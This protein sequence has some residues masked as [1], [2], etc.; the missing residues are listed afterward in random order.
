MPSSSIFKSQA[1]LIFLL[2]ISVSAQSTLT[3]P[4]TVTVQDQTGLPIA[5]ATVTLPAGSSNGT[6]LRTDADGKAVFPDVSVGARTL[7]VTATGFS[8]LTHTASLD[9]LR[10]GTIRIVLAP[11]VISEEVVISATRTETRVSDTP[12]SIAV[13]TGEDLDSS[14]AARLD[15]ALRQIPGFSLFRRS[16]SRVANPTTQGVSLR[17]VGAS[18]AS[19]AVVLEDG[20]PL[21]DPFG[22]W[23]YWGRVPRASVSSIEVVRGG[24]SSLYGSDALGGVVN[25][26]TRK[27]SQRAL[28]ME[29]SYGTQETFDGSLFTA[30]KKGKWSASLAAEVF[31][32][33]GYIL[34]EKPARGR[35]DV[36]ANS[37][38]GAV[39][40]TVQREFA[41]DST[42]FVRGSFFNETRSNGTPLQTNSTHIRQLSGGADFSFPT[43]GNFGL[44]LYSGIERFDQ[45]FTAASA[46]RGSE[47]L[48][49]VQRVPSQATGAGF[50]WMRP[51]G[52][53]TIVAG[54]DAREVRGAS[55]EIVFIA[56]TASSLV[57]AGGR[58]RS[59][60][61]F[62][63]DLVRLSPR[64]L[65]KLNLRVDGWNNFR[66]QS[67]TR[68]LR[69]PGLISA[70][71]FQ[72]RS[73]H[74]VSPHL[75]ALYS[76]NDNLSFSASFYKAFRAP[77]LNE[78]YR[79]FRVGDV[80]TLANENLRSER[81]SGI[82]L[83]TAL[84]LLNGK[85]R[86]RSTFFLAEVSQPVTNVTIGIAPGLITRKRQNLGKNRSTGLEAEVEGR[87]G[88]HWNLTA[89]YLF[90]N[91]IVSDFPPNPS[92]T[93]LR[94][95]QVPR[96]QATF[97]LRYSGTGGLIAALQGRGSSS[98][99]DDDQNLFRLN[100]YF[101]VDGFVS[102]RI[103][104]RFALFAAAENLLNRRY[105]VGRTPIRTIGPPFTLRGG[106]QLDLR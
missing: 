44:R 30:G 7:I 15:D 100:P 9:E 46:D 57:D 29:L 61:V 33:G 17:G 36:P 26:I 3:A 13:I 20:L 19:R 55:D 6:R 58:E 22:G 10:S 98:Q 45:N 1:V 74:A 5:D 64:F 28:S 103:F 41:R 85:L 60:G 92:L 31:R 43:A 102:R 79:S 35:V 76:P 37:R 62:A 70:I 89:G 42:A 83:G 25:I 11:A 27:T 69:T 48:T 95:P 23:V 75:S 72:D 24:A 80:L 51:F 39:E 34:V 8:R 104:H 49:R 66:A 53:H 16:S 14:A 65:L 63:E 32:T 12:E 2:F 77:T 50:Q 97:Q 68:S 87:I 4:L 96:H 84:K 81:L 40:L 90:V 78:L 101:T 18:G 91:S 86:V 21:N 73:E 88:E 71:S 93:G 59:G 94:V 105:D 54:A 38:Q 99:F 82:D 47:S 56:N 52:I 106:L 67:L